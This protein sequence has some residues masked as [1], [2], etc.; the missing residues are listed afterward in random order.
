MTTLDWILVCAVALLAVQGWRA[1]FIGG[2]LSL[3][4]FLL[5]AWLA[6]RFAPL[7]LPEGRQSAY[8]PLATLAGAACGGAVLATVFELAGSGIKRLL[9]VPFLGAAD[10]ALGSVLGVL[11][12]LIGIWLLAIVLMRLPGPQGLRG[13]VRRSSVVHALNGVMPPGDRVLGLISAFDP[14]P[15]IVGPGVSMLEPPPTGALR[16]PRAVALRSSVVRVRA[17]ACGFSVEGSGWVVG[18][19]LVVTNA[20]VVAGDQLPSAQPAGSGPEHSARVVV[21]DRRNDLAVLRVSGLEA[22][23]LDMAVGAYGRPAAIL[24]FPNDG[25]YDVSPARVGQTLG[26]LTRDA[27]GAGPVERA[28]VIIRGRIRSGNSGGPVIDRSG[29]VVATVFSRTVGQGPPGGYGIPPSV[30][31]NALQRAV[32][33][34]SDRVGP[35]HR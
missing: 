4:G 5:G 32:N 22:P 9:P 10:G 12:A 19:G 15:Q 35:C 2:V 1:G 30:V 28:V 24:G 25:A 16:F 18:P 7:I 26:I 29:R 17:I 27:Y 31:A 21:F 8:A 23:A 11:L 34:G 14:L 3:A 20:H 6:A 33:G 13:E